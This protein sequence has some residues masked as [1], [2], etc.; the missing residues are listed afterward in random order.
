MSSLEKL[1]HFARLLHDVE[2]VTRVA[3]RPDEHAQTN[4]AEHTF[5]L[6]MHC[7]CL[8]TVERLDLDHERVLKYALAH[9]IV[10]VYA[11][12]TFAYD[13]EA[14]KTKDA[15][16][17]KAL[18]RIEKEYAEFPELVAAIHEYHARN[19]PEAAFVYAVDK[20]VDPLN[21]SMETKQ[22]MWKE[23]DISFDTL[24]T[25]K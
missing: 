21:I 10:E 20:L 1:E 9:D 19:T 23:Y 4:T 24:V 13:E 18:Q 6:A 14:K 12:D 22:S 5:E 17:A 7:W 2:R 3:R 16:E 15:R 25:N 8:M 11:G